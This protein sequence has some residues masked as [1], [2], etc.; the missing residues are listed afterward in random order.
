VDD[1][2]ARLMCMAVNLA[3]GASPETNMASKKVAF[4]EHFA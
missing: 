3:L 1:S 2:A 4:N